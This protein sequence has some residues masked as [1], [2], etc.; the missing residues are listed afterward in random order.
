MRK[1]CVGLFQG[2]FNTDLKNNIEFKKKY[3]FIT[4]QRGRLFAVITIITCLY[5]LYLDLIL[6]KD[7]S[8]DILYRQNLLFVHIAG[9]ALSLAYFIVYNVLLKPQ[10]HPA[11]RAAKVVVVSNVFLSLLTA[12]LLSLNSQ[13]FT[14]NIDAYFLMVFAIALII[15]MYPRWILGAY[16]FV[17]ILFLIALSA[18]FNN[19]TIAIKQF[20]STTIVLTAMVLFTVLYRYNV[21]SFL[22]EQML[23]RDKA[24]LIKLFEINPFPLII[25][26]FEDGKIQYANNKA[27]LFYEIPKE[28]LHALNNKDLYKNASDLDVIYKTLGI[29]G[30]V[31]D[32]VVEQRTVLGEIK[33]P[34]VNYELIDYFGEKSVL[35]GVVDIAEIKRMEHELTIHASTD[36]L[37]G[38]LNR[39]VGMD[40]V[41]K[42]YEAA[43]RENGGFSLCFI[44]VDNLKAVN[45]KFGHQEG[46]SLILEI[47][48]IIKEEMKP[49]DVIFRYGGDEFMVLCGADDEHEIDTTCYRI[50]QRFEALNKENYKP[51]PIDA[52]TGIFSYNPEMD[53]SVEQIIEIV[54]KKMYDNKLKKKMSSFG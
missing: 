33:C 39:R 7:S 36:V 43:Q 38:V 35:S 15:P 42:R 46:D 12:A 18:F 53:L 50:A 34:I 31:S 11:Y 20:N 1:A 6:Y 9:L 25:F 52:S 14:G 32:Y 26:A 28:R 21:K 17:H 49:D 19:N 48:G 16:G 4:L 44:D 13:R 23:K 22:S 51:Y 27:L 54:D 24:N 2:F 5:S 30:R 47:C 40:L 45:D 10:R 8:I 37:T 3:T 41:R 29:N